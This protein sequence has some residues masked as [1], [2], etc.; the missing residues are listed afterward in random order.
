MHVA[1]EF[2]HDLTHLSPRKSWYLIGPI[3]VSASKLGNTSPRF[4]ILQRVPKQK[5]CRKRKRE[6]ALLELVSAWHAWNDSKVKVTTFLHTRLWNQKLGME[7][8]TNGPSP[9]MSREVCIHDPACWVSSSWSS[10]LCMQAGASSSLLSIELFTSLR[11][12]WSS[13]FEASLQQKKLSCT[14][15]E[16]VV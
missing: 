6:F 7:S 16:A 10:I 12:V 5:I 4:G 8:C 13:L 14:N 15:W 9:L 11:L 3:V 1:K 2:L